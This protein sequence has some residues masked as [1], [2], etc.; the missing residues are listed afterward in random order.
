MDLA[1][2]FR[3]QKQKRGSGSLWEK[4]VVNFAHKIRHIKIGG[5]LGL[6]RERTSFLN[7]LDI[8]NSPY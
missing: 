4:I 3:K 1:L 7:Y 8:N 6:W 5:D 2:T